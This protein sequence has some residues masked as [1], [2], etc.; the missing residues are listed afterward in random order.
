MPLG[1]VGGSQKYKTGK[2]FSLAN[3]LEMHGTEFDNTVY[4]SYNFFRARFA[5]RLLVAHCFQGCI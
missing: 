4:N 3:C 5:C 1:K 2:Y